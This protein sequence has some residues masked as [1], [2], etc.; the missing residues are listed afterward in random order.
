MLN[1]KYGGH[2][3]CRSRSFII[4]GAEGQEGYSAR[5]LLKV[6][7]VESTDGDLIRMVAT[8]HHC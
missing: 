2:E 8:V 7:A 1:V 5:E 6:Q 4:M 3:A